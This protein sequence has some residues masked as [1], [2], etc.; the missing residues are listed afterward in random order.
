M[1][2]ATDETLRDDKMPQVRANTDSLPFRPCV[3]I[4][5]VNSAGL[6]WVG[7]RADMRGDAEGRGQW[8]QMPQGGIDEGEEPEDAARR[9]LRE[10]TGIRSVEVIGRTRDWLTY[11]LPPELIG[12]AWGGRFRGQRQLWFAMRFTGDDSEIDIAP[13]GEKPEFEAWQWMPIDRLVGAI[14]PFKQEVYGRVIAE[15]APL[16]RR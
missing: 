1:T 13:A 8:W 2:I 6:V 11:N 15:L 5:A 3:G 14:V 16:V 7:R 10:E 12:V 9:E 4:M